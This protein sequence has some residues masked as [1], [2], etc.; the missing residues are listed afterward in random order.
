MITT[1][2]PDYFC[3]GRLGLRLLLLAGAD[4]STV[5]PR[6]ARPSAESAR[7]NH[8]PNW[9]PTSFKVNRT[10]D[11]SYITQPQLHRLIAVNLV[12]VIAR[13]GCGKSSSGS[14]SPKCRNS[15]TPANRSDRCSAR[16]CRLRHRR[17]CHVAR[18]EPIQIVASSNMEG[19]SRSR[20]GINTVTRS[21]LPAPQLHAP[22]P[23]IKRARMPTISRQS[24]PALP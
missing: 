17:L 24:H 13:T 21:A 3:G 2:R 12:R 15:P 23:R 18:R 16:S 1:P 20:D 11:R 10:I 5:H 19:Q 7:N 8:T 6:K 9:S 22:A 4:C 14:S